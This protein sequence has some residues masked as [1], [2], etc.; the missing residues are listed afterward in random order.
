MN[1][2]TLLAKSGLGWQGIGGIILLLTGVG[3]IYFGIKALQGYRFFPEQE[4]NIPEED[5][6]EPTQAKALQKIKTTMPDFNGGEDRVFTEWKIGYTVD[7]EKYTPANP[8]EFYLDDEKSKVEVTEEE[9]EA[10]EK[11]EKTPFGYAA[12]AIGVLLG[13]FGVVMLIDKL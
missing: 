8:Q 10:E 5:H 7:G 9:K 6:Y 11:E 13:V 3:L 2:I 4:Y 12:I 1:E